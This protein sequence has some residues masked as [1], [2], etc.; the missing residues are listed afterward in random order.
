[1]EDKKDLILPRG[2]GPATDAEDNITLE[3]KD[4]SGGDSLE[5]KIKRKTILRK[6]MVAYCDRKRLDFGTV[7]FR[8]FLVITLI[9][10]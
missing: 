3:V 2:P 5:F 4:P 7:K 1:M 9:I 8:S 10:E 6:M